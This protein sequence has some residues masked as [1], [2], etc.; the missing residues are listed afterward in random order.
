MA[1]PKRLPVRAAGIYSD[2]CR[3]AALAVGAPHAE[4][5]RFGD[6][7][8]LAAAILAS[9]MAFIDG[10][11]VNVALPLIGQDLGASTQ[12][13]QWVVEAYALFLAALLLPGGALGDHFGRRRIFLNGVLVF[14]VASL[15]CAL[16]P[17]A[18]SLI[19]ARALQGVGAALLVP[20][21]LALISAHFPPEA[22]GRAIG[23]WSAASALTMAA[24][25]VLGGWLAETQG[26]RMIFLINL[27]LGALVVTIALLGIRE[28]RGKG[29]PGALDWPGALF[30]TG[31]LAALVFALIEAPRL[32]IWDGRV[33]LAA[34]GGVLAGVL[35]L[36]RQLRASRPMVPPGL[37][38]DRTF[39]GANL[40]TFAVY[41]GLGGALFFLPLR[42]IEVHGYSATAAAA[43][44]LPF[45]AL[46][47]L[48]SRAAGTLADRIGARGP[49]VAGP[50]LAA[51]GYAVLMLPGAEAHGYWTGTLPGILVLGAG[52]TLTVAPLT[53]T[54]MGAAP[55]ALT[56]TAS[57]LN[58]AVSRTAG[59]LAI[60]ALGLLFLAVSDASLAARLDHFP[61]EAH[62][63]SH[64][65]GRVE[66]P[67]ALEAR[68]GAPLRGAGHA[69]FV[70]GYRAVMGAAAFLSASGAA[71]AAA[72][73]ARGRF[74]GLA[75]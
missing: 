58:N 43:A 71:F 24:G 49:L 67:P 52:M 65:F 59:L 45:V 42:L 19:T 31:G 13:L 11:V 30:A 74:S 60:A 40:L 25:P 64:V 10:T 17:D 36:R 8:V 46:M 37:F 7:A 75:K 61:A 66:V 1:A 62:G 56:G 38:A 32:G 29:E 9:A 6:V 73:I 26:W 28:S 70:D 21:S 35:F 54:V 18:G 50:L 23:T 57:G 51:L 47:A 5:S 48:F 44:F 63:L 3:E 16:A 72:L 55:D 4:R 39:T 22:R 69:A 41:A 12:A 14:T 15:W 33:L 53:A 27:P 20:G 2:P 68:W 34:G